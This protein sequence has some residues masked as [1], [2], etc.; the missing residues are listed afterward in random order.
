MSSPGRY[1]AVRSSLPARDLRRQYE[2]QRVELRGT[3]QDAGVSRAHPDS[4][5]K[6]WRRASQPGRAVRASGLRAPGRATPGAISASSGPPCSSRSVARSLSTTPLADTAGHVAHQLTTTV[7]RPAAAAT[8]QNV[9]SCRSVPL[10][11]DGRVNRSRS[12][13]TRSS[14]AGAR[15]IARVQDAAE[16]GDAARFEALHA[17]STGRLSGRD[18]GPEPRRILLS[19]TAARHQAPA[20]APVA[21]ERCR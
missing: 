12:V 8:S 1:T 9:F 13:E 4:W 5:T 20:R 18:G 15:V 11:I 3:A 19:T 10:A 21:V 17:V 2:V 16:P 6:R 14:R 7:R